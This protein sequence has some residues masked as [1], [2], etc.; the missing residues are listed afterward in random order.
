[1]E[2]QKPSGLR[3]W[4]FAVEQGV[5]GFCS[6]REELNYSI[7]RQVTKP[8]EREFPSSPPS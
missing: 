6:I 1:M 5:A 3:E 4:E 7:T 8:A 2:P